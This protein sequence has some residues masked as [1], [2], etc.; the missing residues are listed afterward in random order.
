[1]SQDRLT[2][3][4]STVR[5]RLG[6]RIVGAALSPTGAWVAEAEMAGASTTWRG[7]GVSADVGEAAD[8]ATVECVER[9]AQTEGAELAV[10]RGS[11]RQL[12]SAAV[13]PVDLGLHSEAQYLRAG[14][15][16]ARLD[17]D[18]VRS[19]VATR[20][21][22]DGS[23]R[24]V[25]LE[26][27]RPGAAMPEPPMVIETSS[28][29]AAHTDGQ[30][31]LTAALC[32]VIERDAAQRWWHH[33]VPAAVITGVH[34]SAATAVARLR[35][36]GNVVVLCR[37]DQDLA[38]PTFLVAALRGR[39]AALG[40]GTSEDSAA[41]LDHALAELAGHLAK[42]PGRQLVHLPFSMVRTSADHRALFDDGP[43]HE[44]L[45]SALD[46]TISPAAHA[47]SSPSKVSPS[48]HSALDALR[49]AGLRALVCDLT[50]PILG[51]CGLVVTR[52]LIP[53]LLPHYVGGDGLRL[54]L[55]RPVGPDSYRKLRTLLPHPFG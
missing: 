23:E 48:R 6:V 52:A 17:P 35:A 25:P 31:A 43:L 5:D 14:S 16:L 49:Q 33:R 3:A 22:P 42:P 2:G 54:G 38:V 12:A 4:A 26:F 27:L 29:T 46:E 11:Q 34:S 7:W 9:W 55:T 1:V 8:L 10:V 30:A 24:L 20:S 15:R 53:G 36:S 13:S 37:I 39:H 41:A 19:W 47:V 40:L 28:G 21:W 51:D 45:R 18:Q 44:A 32:E 50:P